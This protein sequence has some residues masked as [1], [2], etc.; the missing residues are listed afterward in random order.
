[1]YNYPTESQ[2]E[3]LEITINSWDQKTLLY[4]STFN[5]A[6]AIDFCETTLVKISEGGFMR[7]FYFLYIYISSSGA[8]FLP[9]QLMRHN[10]LS[11]DT[12]WDS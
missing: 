12:S 2:K 5:G 9:N 1:M 11:E 10:G 8:S 6:S 7:V 3:C 4:Q